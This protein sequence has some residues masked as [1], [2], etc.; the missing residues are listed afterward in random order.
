MRFF[1]QFSNLSISPKPRIVPDTIPYVDLHVTLFTSPHYL[2]SAAFGLPD[3]E[4]VPRMLLTTLQADE[5]PGADPFYTSRVPFNSI[6]LLGTRFNR[7]T[8]GDQYLY[9]IFSMAPASD[10]FIANLLGVNTTSSDGGLREE[11]VSWIHRKLW[12]SYPFEVPRVTFEELRLDENLW[13]TAGM[14]SFISCMETMALMGKNVANLIV[15]EWVSGRE[16]GGY[17]KEVKGEEV[18]GSEGL[19]VEL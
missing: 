18:D 4:A 15:E 11:D 1:P 2:S 3:A 17:A 8:G 13:Y 16:G 7:R 12:Q 10:S 9:K 19:Q 6:S 5:K 14:E